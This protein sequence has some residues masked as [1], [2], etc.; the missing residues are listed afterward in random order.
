MVAEKVERTVA[1]L[2]A[3]KALLKVVWKEMILVGKKAA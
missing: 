2:A 3:W 1:Y